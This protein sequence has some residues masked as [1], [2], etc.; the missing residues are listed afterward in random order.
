MKL[1]QTPFLFLFYRKIDL[2][3][4][5][6][7]NA[8][9]SHYDTTHNTTLYKGIKFSVLLVPFQGRMIP[10][11]FSF[12]LEEN[13]E[14]VNRVYQ[15]FFSLSGLTKHLNL[16]VEQQKKKYKID[17]KDEKYNKKTDKELQIT[18]MGPIVIDKIKI[19]QTIIKEIFSNIYTTVKFLHHIR[20]SQSKKGDYLIIDST[21]TEETNKKIKYRAKILEYGYKTVD[22]TS[23][24]QV[25][26]PKSPTKTFP[27]GHIANIDH[28]VALIAGIRAAGREFG[29]QVELHFCYFHT[30][31]MLERKA[32]VFGHKIDVNGKIGKFLNCLKFEDFQKKKYKL[33]KFLNKEKFVKY[34]YNLEASILRAS[35]IGISE[36]KQDEEDEKELEERI[37]ILSE[38]THSK[39]VQEFEKYIDDLSERYSHSTWRYHLYDNKTCAVAE[40]IDSNVR[41]FGAA[42]LFENTANESYHA[43]LKKRLERS[44][45]LNLSKQK[46]TKKFYEQI[47]FSQ[48]AQVIMELIKEDDLKNHR[49]LHVDRVFYCYPVLNQFQY[50][51]KLFQPL[52]DFDFNLIIYKKFKKQMRK[53]FQKYENKEVEFVRNVSV[54]A[55]C[56]CLKKRKWRI[57]CDLFFAWFLYHSEKSLKECQKK[58]IEQRVEEYISAAK[59]VYV[60][61]NYTTLCC[62]S[63]YTKFNK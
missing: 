4:W 57:P 26:K 36:K 54:S 52:F 14:N 27:I 49:I 8:K 35:T 22:P 11:L 50:V 21:T 13:F 39:A 46:K 20:S 38:R 15:F 5:K 59:N 19:T 6:N 43:R 7:Q 53:S 37:K 45:S 61:N 40:L 48:V 31:Q 2:D 25:N 58:V 12:Y 16:P 44:F 60:C 28:G 56:L 51:M 3:R 63:C 24:F 41:T 29:I 47:T 30:R 23:L 33:I 9:V 1:Y 32:E 18:L 55:E 17:L 42:R 34:F 62:E 10:L